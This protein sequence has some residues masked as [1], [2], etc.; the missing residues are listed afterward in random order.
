MDQIPKSGRARES[1]FPSMLLHR[2]EEQANAKT[3]KRF[4]PSK[5]EFQKSVQ[6]LLPVVILIATSKDC[7]GF[8]SPGDAHHG[9]AIVRPRLG[10]PHDAA[11]MVRQ[12][13]DHPASAGRA[14]HARMLVP[15]PF[16][17]VALQT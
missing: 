10:R 4:Q 15:R 14:H 17:F 12:A 8:A 16:A 11:V 7:L 9:R 13:S 5:L 2:S 6:R 1:W 3:L